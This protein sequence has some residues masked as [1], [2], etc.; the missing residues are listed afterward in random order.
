MILRPHQVRS[1]EACHSEY[2]AGA[3]SVLLVAPTGFGKCLGI[4][5]P[6]LRYD[7]VIVPVEDVRAGDLLMG[8]DSEPRR[9]LG[10][11]RGRSELFRVTPA[12]GTPW[13][14]N[15]VHVLT[16]VNTETSEVIDVDLPTYLRSSKTFKHLHK[17]FAPANGVEFPA[18]E[19]LP[20]D[21]Y[22]LGVWFGDGT[23]SLTGVQVSKPDEEILAICEDMAA[24]YG[25][26]VGTYLS[27]TNAHPCPTHIIRAVPGQKNPLLTAL[28]AIVGDGS[29]LPHAYLTASRE[30]RAAFLAGFLDTD[31]YQHNS[32][33][34][35]VQKVR[36][37]AEGISFVARSLGL[38]ANVRE[39]IVNGASY[40]RVSISGDASWLPLR[41]ARK[42][43]KP[44]RQKKTATRTGITVESIGEGEYAGFELSGDGRFLLGD[45]AVTHNTA[46]ASDLIGRSVAAG[47]R[48]L[49][50]AHRVEILRDTV[51][52]LRALGLRV[53]IIVA[54]FDADPDAPVQ[55]ASVQTI[56]ARGLGAFKPDFVVTDE[57]HRATA[58]TYRALYEQCAPQWHLG[59]TATPMRADG[60]G[61]GDAFER[62]V[63]GATV[64]ELADGEYL[65]SCDAI[66]A[67]ASSREG[68]ALDEAVAVDRYCAGRATVV[69]VQTVARAREV[70][71]RIPRAAAIYG[72]LPVD[73]RARALADFGL[74]ALDVLVTVAVLT[75]GWDCARA[76]TAVLART[77]GHVGL[78][79][80]I[81][82]RVLRADPARPDKR[83]LIVDLGD[84]VRTHGMPADPREFSLEGEPIRTKAPSPR[85]CP[86]C[87]AVR[88]G[89]STQC[90]RCE[91]VYPAPKPVRVRAE[92]LVPFD[93]DTSYSATKQDTYDRLCLRAASRGYKPGWVGHQFRARYGH[94][95]TGYVAR[96]LAHRVSA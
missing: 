15:D 86:T 5:T 51:R 27:K 48:V 16:L 21:P 81:V 24:R 30:D 68:I 64:R 78:Y 22:F 61:L 7:G 72:D 18:G 66:V 88:R 80:Q 96:G 60:A 87:G 35:I 6:V 94:W 8:P 52:R 12:R 4:G 17:Q 54:G 50:V 31:G 43:S 92:S 70:A 79:L 59:L 32:C 65:A 69:F 49:F 33:Y 77:C 20:I 14:C 83:A 82:G 58:A 55:V 26:T 2:A 71:A 39:K 36:S 28:R 3:R 13:V 37:W 46:V 29:K 47:H 62:M 74:G 19:A 57:A 85:L 9:V 23:K 89:E 53:G 75:E 91:T 40:W 93:G 38:R 45:F 34:E 95:P 76:D 56:D 90:W 44:R 67:P 11:T 84:N 73:Q 63:V 10:T 25:L 41:I 1:V 42:R